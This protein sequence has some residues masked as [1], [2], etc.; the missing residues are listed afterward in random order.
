[1]KKKQQQKQKEFDSRK[2]QVRTVFVLM[3]MVALG[4]FG[5]WWK[6]QILCKDVLVTG[7]HFADEAALLELANVDTTL[8]LFD[9]DPYA[10]ADRVKGHPWVKEAH[11]ERLPDATVQIDVT[12][13]EPAMLVIDAQGSPDHYLDAEGYQM[14]FMREAVFDVPLLTGFSAGEEAVEPIDHENVLALLRDLNQLPREVDALLSAFDVTPEGE[15]SLQ[16]APKPGR[17]AIQVQLGRGDYR[18]KLSKLHAFWHQA[19]LASE[20]TDFELID[21]R[22]DSQIITRE[23]RLSH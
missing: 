8:A 10:V 11:V 12:E 6:G 2:W 15:V 7:A 19:V 14:P 21:L 9:I 22:F 20:E 3:L 23:T 13:R 16:T 1:M 18:R 5:W 17:G 4:A